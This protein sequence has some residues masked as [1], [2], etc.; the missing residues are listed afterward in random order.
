MYRE[1]NPVLLI[2]PCPTM[3]SNDDILFVKY[4]FLSSYVAVKYVQLIK[5]KI[6]CA[7]FTFF[8]YKLTVPWATGTVIP[9]LFANE[10]KISGLEN[11]VEACWLKGCMKKC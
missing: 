5:R 4:Y 11:V 9:K 2:I 1:K 7:S 3:A 6:S 10:F 8:F